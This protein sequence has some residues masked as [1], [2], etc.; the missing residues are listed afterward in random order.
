MPK[1]EFT[2][3]KEQF[4][5]LVKVKGTGICRICGKTLEFEYLSRYPE[6]KP[7][8]C[9]PCG[10]IEQKDKEEQSN[11]VKVAVML[12][13]SE[14]PEKYF[15]V[16][17]KN[18]NIEMIKHLRGFVGKSFYIYGQSGSG[19]SH[20]AGYFS[21]R[22]IKDRMIQVHWVNVSQWLSKM[23]A[24]KMDDKS[25]EADKMFNNAAYSKYLV[26]DGIGKGFMSA[27]KIE[28]LYN[29]IDMRHTYGKTTIFTS[30]L[31]PHEL[32]NRF[33]GMNEDV[34]MRIAEMCNDAVFMID[35]SDVWPDPEKQQEAPQ[36]GK[37]EANNDVFAI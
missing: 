16:D 32:S 35:R 10:F 5:G 9:E 4:Q 20:C 25:S 23:M 26:L 28:T 29:L 19:K 2:G 27:A 21:M 15:T 14:I 13:R 7:T 3:T 17:E 34:L 31:S 8:L 33:T 11:K 37:I 24:A 12:D 6:F 36:N 22:M 30:K 18:P 1:N